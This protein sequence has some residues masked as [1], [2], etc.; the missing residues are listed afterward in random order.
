MRHFTC[1][2]D[3]QIRGRENQK[4]IHLQFADALTFPLSLGRRELLDRLLGPDVHV[5]VDVGDH[6]DVQPQPLPPREEEGDDEVLDR[7]LADRAVMGMKP[8]DK[9]VFLPLAPCSSARNGM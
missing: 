8:S 2:R 1:A 9:R 5:P 6:A 7:S 3:T 4:R